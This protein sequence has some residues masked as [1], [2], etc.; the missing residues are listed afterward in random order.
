MQPIDATITLEFL[1]TNRRFLLCALSTFQ[2]LGVVVASLVSWGLVPRYS[3]DTS[4]KA[5]SFPERPCCTKSSNMGWRYTMIVLGCI[6]LG[7]LSQISPVLQK[8]TRLARTGIFFLR[9]VLFTFYESCVPL[10]AHQP[11][12]SR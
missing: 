9:F 1:P 5:C 10:S 12:E 2:P 4:Y 11:F 6:T 8:L 3:C 7:K